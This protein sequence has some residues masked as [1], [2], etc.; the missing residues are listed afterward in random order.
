MILFGRFLCSFIILAQSLEPFDNLSNKNPIIRTRGAQLDSTRLPLPARAGRGL[1]RGDL[2]LKNRPPPHEPGNAAVP[3]A[4]S[5]GVSPLGSTQGGT[6]CKLAGE[7][8]CATPTAQVQ[9]FKARIFFSGNSH[10]GPLLLAGG[11]GEKRWAVRGCARTRADSRF[12]RRR[13]HFWVARGNFLG[14]AIVG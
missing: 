7:D 13:I 8:A 1:G 5:S 9:G 12:G 6:P 10:P 2:N 4:G 11:E 14:K 3:A